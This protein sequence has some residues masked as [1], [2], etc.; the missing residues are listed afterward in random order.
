MKKRFTT[1]QLTLAAVIAAVYAVLTISLPMLSYGAVQIRFSEALTVLPF[2]FPGAIPGLFVGCV[3]SNLFYAFGP[4]DVIVGSLATLLAAVWTSRVKN[5]WLA[6]L[7][8]V[9]CNAVLVGGEIAWLESGGGAGFLPAW[10]FNALTVG[11]GELL[12][13]YVLGMLLLTALPKIKFFRGIIPADK[14]S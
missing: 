1:R 2:L 12:A 14:L 10:G 11:G 6:P 7:P 8:P 13:C 5:K 4:L 3:I 9:V